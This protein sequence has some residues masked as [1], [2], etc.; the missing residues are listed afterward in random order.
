MTRIYQKNRRP[1]G[2]ARPGCRPSRERPRA[3]APGHP[4]GLGA[5]DQFTVLNLGGQFPFNNPQS[6]ITGSAGAATGSTLNLADG[7][8]TG[9]LDLAP[10]VTGHTGN[11]HPGGGIVQN[12]PLPDQA[13]SDARSASG[14]LAGKAADQTFTTLNNTVVI[15]GHSGLNVIETSGIYFTNGTLTFE[16]PSDAKFLINNTGSFNF[17]NSQF[18]AG[19]GV[20]PYDILFNV[21]GGDATVTGG[22]AGVLDGMILDTGGNVTYHDDTLTGALIGNNVAITSAGKVIGPTGGPPSVPEPSQTA[23]LGLGVLGLAGLILTARKRR[24]AA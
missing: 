1:S 5:A 13:A 23:A 9:S 12:S 6:S 2:G 11:V 21:I 18:L 22:G 19:A 7:T 3:D 16:G 20:S 8:I 15:T 14:T 17:S 4:F 10:G 24:V